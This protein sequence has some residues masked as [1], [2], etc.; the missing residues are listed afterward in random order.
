[1]HQ[2][3]KHGVNYRCSCCVVVITCPWLWSLA[4]G[5]DHFPVVVITC[6][7]LWSLAPP[8][9]QLSAFHCLWFL[10][11][12]CKFLLSL[13]VWQC[14]CQNFL[15][16]DCHLVW[17][18]CLWQL[19]H[20]P[21]MRTFILVQYRIVRGGGCTVVI[22]HSTGSKDWFLVSAVVSCLITIFSSSRGKWRDG[23]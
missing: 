12:K 15:I 5:C 17:P 23:W 6:P 14:W 1:M 9:S 8:Q 10:F 4:R 18:Y 20:C 2:A 22:T 21:Y 11:S 13:F 19:H 16:P 3:I 7:W